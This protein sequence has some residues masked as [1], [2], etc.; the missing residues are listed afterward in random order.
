VARAFALIGDTNVDL[1]IVDYN[2]PFL[3][4]L[5]FVRLIR[6]APDS[7]NPFLP[8]IMLTAHSDLRRVSEARDAGVSEFCAK[9]VSPVELARKIDHA[10]MRPRPFV[11]APG[12]FGP[13]RRRRNMPYEGRDRRLYTPAMT[14]G[15][16]QPSF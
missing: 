15:S 6:T 11:R 4:G 3:D 8:I 13:D 2:L 12:Y 7:P 14:G 1:A 5:A 10:I 16:L 9:P